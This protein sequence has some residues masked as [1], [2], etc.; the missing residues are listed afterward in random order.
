MRVECLNCHEA[1][2]IPDERL[3]T[4][5]EI[6]F[7]CPVCKGLIEIQLRSKTTGDSASR[8]QLK[9]K[10]LL[11]GGPLKKRILSTVKSLPPMP[12]TVLKAR[13]IMANPKS[14]F[15]ELGN[16]LE[17]DQGI[18]TKVL[19]L[20]NSTYYGLSGKVSSIH[21]ASIVLGHKTIGELITMGGT[22]SLLGNRLEGYGL[23]AGSLWKHS[24]GVAFGSRIIATRIN[25]ALSNDAFTSGLIHDVGKLILDPY[26]VERW[27]LFEE[28]MADGQQT[29]LTAEK[30]ILQFDHSEIASEVCNNWNI[31]EPLTIAI[32]YHHHPSRS[33]GNELAYIVHMADAIAMMTGLGLGIDGM[34]YRVDDEAMEFLGLQEV[35]VNTIMVEVLEAVKKISEQK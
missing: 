34:L 9:Q 14:D 18:A 6:A 25:S 4:G 3:P 10:D 27:S 19:K 35:D 26:I 21:H 8:A 22:E 28:F 12:Q 30:E 1:F 17:T 5:K 23:D 33:H 31:P 7:P 15:K 13:E 29:F 20:A 11:K 24:L 16:L 32:R 2:D